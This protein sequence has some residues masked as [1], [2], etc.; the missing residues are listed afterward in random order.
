MIENIVVTGAVWPRRR[1]GGEGFGGEIHGPEHH[2]RSVEVD[3]AGVHD[4]EDFRPVQG[5]VAPVHG[6]T[7]PRERGNAA[8]TGHVMETGE[9]VKVMAATGASADGGTSTVAAVEKSVAAETDDQVRIHKA[10]RRVNHSG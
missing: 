3:T 5:E 4:A 1:L 8:G 2:P 10:L 6:H 9:D 7:K